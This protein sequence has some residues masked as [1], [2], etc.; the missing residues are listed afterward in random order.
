MLA[1]GCD[2]KNTPDPSSECPDSAFQTIW[3]TLKDLPEMGDAEMGDSG[4]LAEC[5]TKKGYQLPSV[6]IIRKFRPL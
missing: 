4:D 3:L 5:L 2:E 1:L 6:S